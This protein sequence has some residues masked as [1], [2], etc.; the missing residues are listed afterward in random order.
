MKK[1]LLSAA[2]ALAMALT[3]LPVSVFAAVDL[4][5]KATE[6]APASGVT[7]VQ[8]I[9]KN[10]FSKL[11][12]DNN[13]VQGWA[14]QWTD[15]AGTYGT[16]NKTYWST[17]RTG[18]E[19]GFVNTTAASGTWYDEADLTQTVG[20]TT[21]LR[22]TS[23]T[24]VGNL[25]ITNLYNATSLQVNTFGKALTLPSNVNSLT[26]L[27]I[28]DTN[29]TQYGGTRGTVTAI[30][31]NVGTYNASANPQTVSASGLTLSIT[32]ASVA[33][34]NL[35]GRTNTVTIT[36]AIVST[37]GITLDGTT[38]VSTTTTAGTTTATTYPAQSLTINP[39]AT[40]PFTRSSVAS[41]IRV[42]GNGS[43][44]RIN[45]TNAAGQE[46][47]VKSTGGSVWIDNGSTVGTITVNSGDDRTTTSAPASVTINDGTALGI[48]Y[49][50]PTTPTGVT[51]ES[52]FT[53]NANGK[54]TTAI[55]TDMGTVSIHSAKVA[56]AVTV[57]SGTLNIDG[58]SGTVGNIILG[59]STATKV[60]FNF[61]GTN[62]TGGSITKQAN[63]TLVI[64]AG[65]PAGRSNTFTTLS[66]G[67]YSGQ[68]IKGGI[69]STPIE[70]E[71]QAKWL[72]PDLQFY[73]NTTGTNAGPWALYGKQEL[74][75]AIADA[76][77]GAKT[78][79]NLAVIG[80]KGP[81]AA[82]LAGGKSVFFYNSMADINS[83]KQVATLIYGVST[84]IYLPN[85]INGTPVATWTDA[86]TV[87]AGSTGSAKTYGVNELVSLSS[88]A[89]DT[90]KFVIQASGA[91]VTKLTNAAVNTGNNKNVTVTL[92]NNQITL[93]GAVGQG[94]F[95]DITVTCTTD[96][97]NADGLPVTFPVTVSFDTTTKKAAI[98][99]AGLTPPPQGVVINTA[100]NTIK[101]GDNTYTLSVSGLAKP[102]SDLKVAGDGYTTTGVTGKGIVVTVS[103]P[104]GT[105]TKQA[106]IDALTGTDA[107]FEWTTSPAMKQ[108][109]NRALATIT[110]NTTLENWCT[111][112]Q[113]AAWNLLNTGKS[114]APTDL[115]GTGYN[116]VVLEPYLAV[117]VTQQNNS[118]TMT[119]NL[120][121]SYRVIVVTADSTYKA[122]GVAEAAKGNQSFTKDGY[123]IVQAGRALGTPIT[124]LTD[125]TGNGGVTVTFPTASNTLTGFTTSTV[126]HQDGTYAYKTA[127]AGSYLITR[128]G[129]TGLGT[130]VFNTTE[131]LVSLTRTGANVINGKAGTY[132]YD[133]LQAAVDD[134]LPQITDA[135]QDLITVTA[136]YTGSG[137]IDVTGTARKFKITTRGQTKIE[138]ANNN[139]TVGVDTTGHEFTV[140][141]QQNVASASG[142][143][144]IAAN[145]AQYG[146]ITVSASKAKTGD[147][148]TI[149]ATP[150]QGY[151]V[152]TITAATNTGAPV[153]VT[154]TG[155]LNQY[156]L[157]VPANTTKVTVTPTFV[158]GDNKATFS[159]NTNTT[160]GTA[161]VYTGTS[162]GKV[163]QGKSATV[164]VIPTSGN[165]TM[166]LTAYGNNGATA[167]VSRTGTNSFNVTVPSGATTVTVTPSFDVDNGTP[168]SDV[169][170]N[171][172]AS[173]EISW[174]YRH[175]Y[176][177]GKDTQYTYKPSDYITRGEVVAML[178]KANGSKIVNYANPFK[179]VP[180]N[181]WAYNAVMWAASK[182]L[183][184]TS[185]GY[186]NG[187]GY[188]NRADTVV[189]LYKQ[190]GSL[191]VYGTSGFADVASNAYYS[192]AVTWARQQ[193]LTNGYSGNTYFRPS[194]AISRAEVAT[195]LYR[196]F[197]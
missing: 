28:T 100:D 120:V 123:Y 135:T 181:Y 134:T 17:W 111:T 186:F 98:S 152:N 32:G 153:T 37:G 79:N 164:T 184:D 42:V 18:S 39:K 178:W 85:K 94:A 158:V 91:A 76:G 161:S 104:M 197:A 122:A 22:T 62:Y 20:T 173:N 96:L 57:K 131:P 45:G 8:Y 196:A 106:L 139:F 185:T 191:P 5:A 54:V 180:T 75:T 46:V 44:V 43:N 176:T 93:S 149:T 145:T 119:A 107:T 67:T 24:L 52:N 61:S 159:V 154:A 48:I 15:T 38:T 130:M 143:V 165:R 6:S 86:S 127:T 126:M 148:I 25:N 71:E 114:P 163:E 150:N 23:I 10:D 83:D 73:R 1:R 142:N 157:T 177:S 156:T 112:A 136:D 56:A 146:T 49:N 19:H 117:N 66:L 195:F 105:V 175:G 170:S 147:V 29:Y 3:L 99:T 31:R 26:S 108:E 121:P 116:T 103:A 21:S 68:G 72:S 84:A 36:D 113:R 169:L 162:D 2:L 27:T 13:A 90:I 125:S 144:D 60:N 160:R 183:I 102:A 109:V 171:H 33:S 55:S 12:K 174:A 137:T 40:A 189:I 14:W 168:F 133:N 64:G 155:T 74:A 151:K 11:D 81:S 190:A 88:A 9:P 50:K 167:A 70:T 129:K 41:T 87:V 47:Q 101:V 138:N 132:Y 89:T 194:Y 7:S 63:T 65:W 97:L 193:G 110:N 30:S 80:W 59:D 128:G 188:I 78:V 35:V 187:T 140:Q 118:G 92:N 172:W 77:A 82:A 192:R 4:T 115:T 182:G 95:E 51:G 124:D 179:D 53:V 58:T 16:V 166:G 34:V 69:F 141:L